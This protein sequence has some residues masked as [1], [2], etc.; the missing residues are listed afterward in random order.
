MPTKFCVAPVGA[1]IQWGGVQSE[2]TILVRWGS[3]ALSVSQAAN[4]PLRSSPWSRA[5]LNLA[6]F[7][8]S[9]LPMSGMRTR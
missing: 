4:S 7:C 5:K 6:T 2:A 1:F 9:V 3:S 8:S